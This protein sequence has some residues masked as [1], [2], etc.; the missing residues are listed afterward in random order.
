MSTWVSIKGIMREFENV[1]QKELNN[2]DEGY[3][4]GRHS[5]SA[6]MLTIYVPVLDI[7]IR[8]SRE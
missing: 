2:K 3:T 4:E 6:G 5:P 1:Q 8:L 7:G